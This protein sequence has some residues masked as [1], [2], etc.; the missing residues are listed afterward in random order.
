MLLPRILRL[1]LRP[2]EEGVSA[3]G[4]EV[5]SWKHCDRLVY[6]RVIVDVVVRPIEDC[7][8]L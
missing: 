4:G 2:A 8:S 1:W 5:G 3:V 6:D 7:D